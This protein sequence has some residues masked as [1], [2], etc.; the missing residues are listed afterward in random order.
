MGEA[1][2]VRSFAEKARRANESDTEWTSLTERRRRG[3]S[4]CVYLASSNVLAGSDFTSVGAIRLV[5]LLY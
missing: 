2:L 1:R 3:G 5:L 4:D